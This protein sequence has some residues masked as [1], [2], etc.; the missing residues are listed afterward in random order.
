[1]HRL[2]AFLALALLL[3]AIVLHAVGWEEVAEPFGDLAFFVGFF[4]LLA[5]ASH[6]DFNRWSDARVRVLQVT[7][8]IPKPAQQAPIGESGTIGDSTHR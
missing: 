4:A 1:V 8:R 6:V 3:V 5:S 7:L 2:L